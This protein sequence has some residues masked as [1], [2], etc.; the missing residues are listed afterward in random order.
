MICGLA[1]RMTACGISRRLQQFKIGQAVDPDMRPLLILPAW[2][3]VVSNCA[4]C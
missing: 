1:Q 4:G 2:S 3:G